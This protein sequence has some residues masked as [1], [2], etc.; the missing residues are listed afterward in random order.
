MMPLLCFSKT[1]YAKLGIYYA[2][3]ISFLYLLIIT[4]IT[5]NIVSDKIVYSDYIFFCVQL[6]LIISEFI[7]A[8]LC[9]TSFE[10]LDK[11]AFHF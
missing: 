8:S 2:F 3:L 7:I 11:V 1:L 4:I 9:L 5:L 10:F 6:Y